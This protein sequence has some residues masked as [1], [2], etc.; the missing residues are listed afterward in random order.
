MANFG[1]V[2]PHYAGGVLVLQVPRCLFVLSHEVSS[3]FL[4]LVGK[5]SVF[6]SAAFVFR[7]FRLVCRALVFGIKSAGLFED[8]TISVGMV[9]RLP[10]GTMYLT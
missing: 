2:Y 3:L 7:H 5:S 4:L 10:G 6:R 9:C 1:R 8:S